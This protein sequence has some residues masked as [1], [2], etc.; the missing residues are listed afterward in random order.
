MR[1]EVSEN[2]F[3]TFSSKGLE[4]V[5]LVGKRREREET[6][7]LGNFV[8]VLVEKFEAKEKMITSTWVEL[9]ILFADGSE[10][11][12]F[13]NPLGSLNSIRW[14]EEIDERCILNPEISKVREHLANVI[15]LQSSKIESTEKLVTVVD[16]FGG[17][18]IDR[19]F[20]FHAGNELIWPSNMNT[21]ERPKVIFNLEKKKRLVVDESY[22]EEC[23]DAAMVKIISACP[24][25]GSIIM[26]LNLVCLQWAA[27]EEAGVVPR[28]SIFLHG[29][30][31]VKKTTYASFVTQLFNRDL[32]LERPERFNSSIPAVLEIMKDVRHWVQ[33]LDDLYPADNPEMCRYQEKTLLEVLRVV[34]DG[35]EPARVRGGKVIKNPPQCGMLLTGEYYIGTG[36][37]AA[38]LLPIEIKTSIGSSELAECQ[39]KPLALSTFYRF[40]LQWFVDNYGEIVNN[41]VQLRKRYLMIADDDRY[42][43]RLKEMQFCLESAYKVYLLYRVEKNFMSENEMRTEYLKFNASLRAIVAK[44]N[45]RVQKNRINGMNSQI[46]YLGIIRKMVHNREFLIVRKPSQFND[47]KHDAILHKH[48]LYFRKEKLLHKIRQYD[49]NAVFEDVLHCLEQKQALTRG[50]TT[51][52]VQLYD[53][54][55]GLRFYAIKWEMLCK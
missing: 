41:L 38:R 46:D 15:R 47:D 7:F 50:K 13:T 52:S 26:A 17:Y 2:K 33:L 36:S 32:P 30:S 37:D 45:E 25:A 3:Y 4:L 22:S 48:H 12:P 28:C 35:V 9:K 23:A 44:Q 5:S 1:I 55:K 18:K 40:Y 51:S 14:S 21:E 43:A 34:S 24:E 11:E 16:S 39:S 31:G 6:K 19:T 27:F 54:G 29:A 49:E 53:A 20:V 10:R 8:P 42:H